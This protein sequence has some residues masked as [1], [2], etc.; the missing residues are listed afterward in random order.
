M[1]AQH[2]QRRRMSG[3]KTPIFLELSHVSLRELALIID[4]ENDKSCNT[5]MK[6]SLIP[7]DGNIDK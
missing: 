3:R 7:N 5:E 6:T 1:L 4:H 2:W